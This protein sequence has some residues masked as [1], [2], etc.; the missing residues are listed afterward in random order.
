MISTMV[1]AAFRSMLLALA[2]AAGLRILRVRNVLAQK[3]AWM[4][5]LAAA[6]AMPLVQP[7]ASKWQL[8]PATAAIN[9]PDH[10]LSRLAAAISS[11]G[12]R[13]ATPAVVHRAE[14]VRVVPA[15]QE[16]VQTFAVTSSTETSSVDLSS[17]SYLSSN[18]YQDAPT[19]T[20]PEA[21]ANVHHSLSLTELAWLAYLSVAVTLLLRLFLGLSSAV[22]IWIGGLPVTLRDQPGLAAGLALRA[23]REVSSPVTIGSAVVLSA[24]YADWDT[25]K[26]RIVLA[27][28]RSHI[29]Q[30]D[31]Y[32]QLVAGLYAAIFWFSP[33][34]WWLKSKLSD[35]AETI[36]DRAGLEQAAN[37]SSYAQILLEFAAAPRQTLTGVAMARPGTL[38]R[39]IERLLNDSSF[40]QAFAGGRSRVLVA[41]LL[42]PVALF[43]ATSLIRVKAAQDAPAPPPAAPAA[44]ATPAPQTPAAPITGQAA[45][46]PDVNTTA[47]PA[48]DVAQAPAPAPAPSVVPDIAPLAPVAPP[49]ATLAP[50][51]PAAPSDRVI[52]VPKIS[53]RVIVMPDMPRRIVIPEIHAM[54]IRVPNPAPTIAVARA[55]AIAKANTYA[56]YY[57]D[58]GES[59]G[60]VRGNEHIQFSGDLHTA[61]IDKIRKM[62]HG[63]FLWFNHDGKYYYVDDPATLAKIEAMYKPMELLGK[64]QEELGRKQEAL[65]KQQEALGEKQEQVAVPT[66][67]LSKEMAQLNAAMATLQAKIGKTITQQELAEL[68]D[69]LGDLQGRL[70]D[71]QGRIGD[72][73]GALGEQQGKLGEEMGRLGEEQGRL[74]AEQGKIGR[75]ADRAVRSIIDESLKNG[76]A[77]PVQ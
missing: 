23:S 46:E 26:L 28:E 47:A 50:V 4:L 72:G 2:V 6:I 60:I 14:P 49:A 68:Q 56:Y 62:A 22:L 29:R 31:F 45:P 44:Q 70:G 75:D 74:G 55:L 34:G 66:P 67:D 64:Q 30:G 25:E 9:L 20:A 39:R 41:I 7:L 51:A 18:I 63:D 13:P 40:R 33:L 61:D 8:L 58:N 48:P 53:S 5:V 54:T 11:L 37:C 12:E 71:L 27:H 42:V 15:M 57:S 43:A 65:G 10:P 59:F 77:H 24:D 38:S 17:P 36:S 19:R 16:P 3:L 32:L 73:M 21:S 35:L 52:V 69:K 1:E 76:T